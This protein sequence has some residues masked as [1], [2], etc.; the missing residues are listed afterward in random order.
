M[1]FDAFKSMLKTEIAER[2]TTERM[3]LDRV[4]RVT[5][6]FDS[7]GADGLS[8]LQTRPLRHTRPGISSSTFSTCPSIARPWLRP[9]A[10]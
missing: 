1:S 2:T 4:E 8:L 7:G 9:P 10:A 6:T 3:R 5:W